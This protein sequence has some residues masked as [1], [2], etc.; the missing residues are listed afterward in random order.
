MSQHP[1]AAGALNRQPFRRY[2]AM[3]MRY[4]TDPFFSYSDPRL[5]FE[6]MDEN[7]GY[8]L[9]TETIPLAV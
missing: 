1:L 5:V 7:Q 6:G 9:R 8:G 4:D 2:A 3:F